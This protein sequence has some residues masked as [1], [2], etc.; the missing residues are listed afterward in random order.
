MWSEA[1]MDTS[2]GVILVQTTGSAH[3]Q[4]SSSAPQMLNYRVRHTHCLLIAMLCFS[5]LY[6][7]YLTRA[8]FNFFAHRL[9]TA[10]HSDLQLFANV[11]T[12][13]GR[14]AGFKKLFYFFPRRRLS[15]GRHGKKSYI[16]TD[17]L[18]FV[19]SIPYSASQHPPSSERFLSILCSSLSLIHI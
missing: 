2:P 19:V 13:C 4:V 17:Y 1:T 11:K 16:C 8:S 9:C 7:N 3:F 10:F 12:K 6:K 15:C 14:K 18:S 5:L